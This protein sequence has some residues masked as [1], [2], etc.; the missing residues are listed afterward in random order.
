MD[1]FEDIGFGS[2]GGWLT[3]DHAAHMA[4]SAIQNREWETEPGMPD[5]S[6]ADV[7]VI[8]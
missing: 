6:E 8:P 1:D 5:P 3:I 4:A 2:S 7:E